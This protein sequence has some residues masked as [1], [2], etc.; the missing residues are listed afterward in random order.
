[1]QENSSGSISNQTGK[2][3]F[4]FLL[5]EWTV[6]ISLLSILCVSALVVNSF[7]LFVIWKDPK[8]CLRTHS[9]FL[10]TNLITADL[11]GALAIITRIAYRYFLDQ[12]GNG[13]IEEG[14]QRPI[15]VS[16]YAALLVSCMTV[17]F[18]LG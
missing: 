15:V 6:S 1:M 9:T 2:H 5:S 12:S 4:S 3:N 11:L 8:K 13:E 16:G 7:L 18:Y 17:F 10:I 14:F